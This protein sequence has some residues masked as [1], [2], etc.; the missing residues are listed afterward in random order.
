MAFKELIYENEWH[1]YEEYGWVNIFQEGDR[2]FVQE[3]NYC[4]M[5][6]DNDDSNVPLEEVTFEQAYELFHEWE[7]VAKKYEEYMQC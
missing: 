6:V 5:N 3:F 1:T 2:Y 7:E 4:V